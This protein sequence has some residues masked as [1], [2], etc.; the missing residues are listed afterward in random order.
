MKNVQY[1]H[2]TGILSS[3]TPLR[4]VNVNG[5]EFA[6]IISEIITCYTDKVTN[7][8]HKIRTERVVPMTKI[9]TQ[10]RTVHGEI[11]FQ[12]NNNL[13]FTVNSNILAHCD[14]ATFNIEKK[15]EPP[16]IYE[17]STLELVTIIRRA[18]NIYYNG[19]FSI[20]QIHVI[21]YIYVYTSVL[22]V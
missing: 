9:V 21:I 3:D 5:E 16:C 4:Y 12:T 11:L 19:L 10:P 17:D 1:A 14:I 22:S 20:R 8:Q 15:I 2:A 6:T 18:T 7:I 13:H